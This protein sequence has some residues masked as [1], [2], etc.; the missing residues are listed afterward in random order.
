LY[1]GHVLR[2]Q[3]GDERDLP[4]LRRGNGHD[5]GPCVDGLA[6]LDHNAIH[7]HDHAAVHLGD[8]PHRHAQQDALVPDLVRKAFRDLAGTT[9]EKPGLRRLGLRADALRPGHVQERDLIR[10][11]PAR[12]ADAGLHGGQPLRVVF[13]ARLV[14][15]V[16]ER[17]PVQLCRVRRCRLMTRRVL[18][19]AS[20]E[21]AQP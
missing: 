17:L 16:L 4:P 11:E 12:A 13:R 7:G 8:A 10:L 3:L 20:S 21:D 6:S 15:Q 9:A 19:R 18:S 2:R 5:H 1:E 14:Q